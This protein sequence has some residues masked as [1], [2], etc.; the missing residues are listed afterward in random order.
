MQLKLVKNPDIINA[1]ADLEKRP[2]VVGFAAETSN[3]AENG[4]EKLLK[5]K[6]DLLFANNAIDSFNSDSI[7]V[8]AISTDTE[9]ELPA[10]NKHVV[11]RNMLQLIAD[12][13]MNNEKS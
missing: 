7:S 3:I 2:L 5:K 12:R 11:A 6:L 4:R 9:S 10:G 13:L 8:T 1:V